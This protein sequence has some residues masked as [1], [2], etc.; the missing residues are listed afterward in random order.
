MILLAA[1]VLAQ[2]PAKSFPPDAATAARIA[3]LRKELDDRLAKL[4]PDPDVT[5]YAKAAGWTV[6]H[7]EWFVKDSAAQT[8]RVLEAGIGR[9]KELAA[10]RTPWR[11]VVGRP[12]VRGFVSAVDGSVQ[13]AAVTRPAGDVSKLD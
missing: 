9:A 7:N 2:P 3:E 11:D 6:R 8:V 1:L 12:V 5:V 10:G 13:P 4:K